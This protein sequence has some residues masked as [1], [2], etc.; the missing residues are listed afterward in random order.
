MKKVAIITAGYFP[1]PAVM[2]GAVESLVD[3]LIDEN[4]LQGK[5]ELNVYSTFNPQAEKIA[6]GYEST[7]V[8]YIKTPAIIEMADKVIYFIAKNLLK[9][10]KNMSYRYIIQRMYF[11][12]KVAIGLQKNEYDRVVIENHMTLCNAMKCFDNVD[13]YRGKF[14]YHAHN[15]ITSDFGAKNILE[16]CKAIIS[17]SNYIQEKMKEHTG[18]I[19]SNNKFRVLRNRVNQEKFSHIDKNE[20]DD[21][22]SKYHLLHDDIV[23]MFTGRLNPEKGV[24]ELLRAFKQANLEHCKLMIVGSYYFGSSMKSEYEEELM[25]ATVGIENQII[26]TGHVDYCKMPSYYALADIV[27]VPS[28]W[29]DPAPLTV[30]EAIT[31]GKPLITTASGGIPEYATED[32]AC[33]IKNGEHFVDDLTGAIQKLV[34]SEDVRNGYAVHARGKSAI[35][36]RESYYQ[37]FLSCIDVEV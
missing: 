2:G 20:I 33:I 26:F 34:Q 37:D 19:S 22:R 10:K 9:K 1:V 25:K 3:L 27:A 28:V 31:A 23:I 4:E 13:K 21:L 35:W 30:I 36:T 24:L 6:A 8:H 15:I 5:L 11:I 14:Y 16:Q 7:I 32:I 12:R 29:D 18:S 17:V